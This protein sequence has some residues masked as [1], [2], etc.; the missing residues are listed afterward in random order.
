MR[1]AVLRETNN[2]QPVDPLDGSFVRLYGSFKYLEQRG[3]PAAVGSNQA[4]ANTRGK[5]QVQILKQPAAA[6]CFPDALGFNQALGFSIGRC[7]VDFCRS[8]TA[9]RHNSR[10]FLDQPSGSIDSRARL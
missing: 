10:E 6:K 9:A 5:S 2:L 8:R 4:H 1:A 3:L 7:E